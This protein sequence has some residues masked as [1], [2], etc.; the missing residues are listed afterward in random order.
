MQTTNKLNTASA[1]V[2]ELTAELIGNSAAMTT[3]RNVAA[4]IDDGEGLAPVERVALLEDQIAPAMNS[5]LSKW[6]ETNKHILSDKYLADTQGAV[7]KILDAFLVQ[8]RPQIRR[9]IKEAVARNCVV[10]EVIEVRAVRKVSRRLVPPFH[11][12]L[13]TLIKV[14]ASRTLDGYP[15]PLWIHGPKGNGK[16]TIAQQIANALG[17]PF[18]L[19]AL[20]PTSTESKLIGYRNMATGAFVTGMLNDPFEHGGLAFLDEIDIA[21]PGVLVGMN[22]LLAGS[23]FR[24]PDGN[25]VRRHKNFYILAGSNTNGMG[26]VNGYT[27]NKLDSAVMDRFLQF[28]LGLD[29][30]LEAEICG[31]KKWA[32]YMA[33]IREHIE[34]SN[35]KNVEISPRKTNYGASLLRASLSPEQVLRLILPSAGEKLIETILKDVGPF[36]ENKPA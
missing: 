19:V 7:H 34:N 22:A 24:F 21:D 29:S 15:I 33:R 17:A 11:F 30:K 35:I 8:L 5:I 10:T 12:A 32:A 25:I 9:E 36:K 28:P 27:R 18:Y 16:S 6:L 14:A 31:N 13:P 20:S 3:F 2:A 1:G 4:Q 26:P 23:E